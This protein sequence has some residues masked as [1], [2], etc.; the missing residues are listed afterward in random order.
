MA[1]PSVD[2]SLILLAHPTRRPDISG[3]ASLAGLPAQGWEALVVLPGGDEET[4]V[5]LQ[6]ALAGLQGRARAL[7]LPPCPAGA[8]RNQAAEEARGRVLFFSQTDCRLPPD[9]LAR[10][11]QDLADADLSGV[12]G[13]CLARDPQEPWSRLMALDLELER[14]EALPD[15]VCAAWR[16][17][18]FLEAGGFDPYD[19][20]EGLE[21]FE[22]AYRLRALEGQVALDPELAVRRPLPTSLGA[23]LGLAYHLGRNRFRN[24]L[25]RR[26]LGLGSKGGARRFGQSV[27]ILAALGL[28]LALGGRDLGRALVWSTVCLLLL[29][30]LNRAFLKQLS[31][32]EPEL[33]NRAL[34]WCL[35]RP[36]AWTWGM[37]RASLDR[38]GGQN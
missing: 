34:L 9:L 28:P 37:I 2:Y 14:S 18:D 10:L 20:G 16:S 29:Y 1:R 6:E 13:L 30:P 36:W 23:A 24:I 25:H 33:L 17:R 11:N 19:D 31:A 26:R 4:L 38:M 8:A 3:L 5:E 22:L 12:G 27:L 32:R 21:N 35:L 15:M 7:A